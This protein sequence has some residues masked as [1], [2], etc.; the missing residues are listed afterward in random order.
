MRRFRWWIGAGALLFVTVLVAVLVLTW[1]PG[2]PPAKRQGPPGTG[3]LTIVSLGDSTLSGEGAGDYTA[4]TSGANGDWCHRS[5]NATVFETDVPGIA[6]KVNFACSGAP[7]AQV[8]LGDVRQYTEPSQA[9]QLAGLVKT[10]RVAIVVVALGANDDPHFSQLINDCFQAWFIAGSPPCSTT[11]ES[12]WTT[13]VN[14]MVPK[15]TAAL[16]DVKKVLAQAGYETGDY[17]LVLQ[18]YAAP[19]GPDVPPNLQNLNGCPFRTEDLNWVRDDGVRVLSAGL[20]RAASQAGARFLDLSRAGAGHE[21]CSG[22]ADASKEWFSRLTLR[23]NDLSDVN[24]ASHS[25]Q[26]SFHPN[27]NGHAQIGRCLTEFLATSLP[28]SA[29]LS[30]ADGNLHSTVSIASPG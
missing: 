15:V 1:G 17:Q 19:I 20:A 16:G 29:C 28:T 30:G 24:R 4:D 12:A 18:S 2:T 22:G 8:A 25:L 9:G 6:A 7:S 10:H 14:S 23:L 13:R 26:E 3:P 21:A 5:P 11:V 27:A